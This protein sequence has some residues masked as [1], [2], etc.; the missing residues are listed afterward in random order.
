MKQ[1]ISKYINHNVYILCTL[2]AIAAISGIGVSNT[3][4]LTYQK[5]TDV[6]FTIN[7]SV[8]ITLSSSDLVI[9]DLAPNS[10]ADSNIINVKVESN[11]STGYTLKSSVGNSTTYNT[12]ALIH[13][14]DN[15]ASFTNLSAIGSLSAG[16][17]GYSFSTDNGTTWYGGYDY[18][19]QLV[20]G[21]GG[22]PLYNATPAS[23]INTS[24]QAESNIKFK[25]GA[26]ATDMQAS[27]EYNNVVNFVATVNPAPSK[28]YMQ[29]FTLA[30]CQQNVGLNGNPANVGDV[31][32][33]YDRRD[34]SDYTVRYIN[35][36]C[37]MTQNLRITGTISATDSN[38][39]S[40][41]SFNT[42][43]G[44]DLRG[45]S[46][47]YTAA[48]S[49]LADSTDVEASASAADGPYTTDQ[50]GAWYNYCAASAGEVCQGSTA[51]SATQDICPAGWMLPTYDS[52]GG[53]AVASKVSFVPIYGGNY[54][55]GSLGNATTN[56]YWWSST[57]HSSS[58]GYQYLLY[59][60]NGSMY[61]SYYSKQNGYYV[62][63]MRTS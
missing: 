6:K 37:W 8:S 16:K 52:F 54:Y 33:V 4:A 59:Y 56:G 21:Y 40:P 27:G 36:A 41:A 10:N 62:R 55:N 30:D 28:L 48:Q 20:T 19:E 22:L 15:N 45:S 1:T 7:P 14:S 51:Q 38:F 47:T 60:S 43:A 34:D 44:G 5:S 58:P 53:M 42:A 23:L 57:M 32:T 13:D 12:D 29:D 26:Y 46:A 3:S 24:T 2:C 35:N 63:C 17:W 31:I 50:L 49:H 61:P 25:I 39:T 11:N 18:N 9:N